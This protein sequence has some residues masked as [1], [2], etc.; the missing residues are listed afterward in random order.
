MDDYRD[1]IIG[2]FTIDQEGSNHWFTI[3]RIS[4]GIAC[5]H[6]DLTMGILMGIRGRLLPPGM[7]CSKWALNGNIIEENGGSDWYWLV[8]YYDLPGMIGGFCLE[9]DSLLYVYIYTVCNVNPII[10]P[11]NNGVPEIRCRPG[12]QACQAGVYGAK[13]RHGVDTS[14]NGGI[15]SHWSRQSLAALSEGMMKTTSGSGPADNGRTGLFVD[16]KMMA[17]DYWWFTKVK[18]TILPMTDPY[19]CHIW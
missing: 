2:F 12:L 9:D 16:Q 11:L 3:D 10:W 19:V 1:K 7:I 14:G 18:Y 13:C 17:V 4:L 5:R 15:W 8:N 6:C